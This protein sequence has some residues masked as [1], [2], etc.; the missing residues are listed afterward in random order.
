MSTDPISGIL[1][2]AAAGDDSSWQALLDRYHDRLRR[3]V[4]IRLDSRLQGRLDPSDILQETYLEAHA[5]LPEYVREPKVPF[6]LWLRFLAGHRL[7]RLHRDHLHRK[8][9]DAGREIPLLFGGSPA[10]SSSALSAE[11]LGRECRP[12]EA[13]SLAERKLQLEEALDRMDPLDREA[14][15]L[16]HFEQLTRAESAVVLGISEAAA[17]K[18][19]LRALDRLR[20]V[21]GSR[22]G[23]LEGLR[24]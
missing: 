11:L 15:A 10:V 23:G 17:A 2:Q 5:R 19:Y 14:L 9:R 16:R 1:R 8:R 24:P 7:G 22:P 4:V 6:F 20:T 21:L 12:S 3:M 18:R 13:A